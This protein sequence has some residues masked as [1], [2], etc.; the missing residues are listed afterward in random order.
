[1]KEGKRF[2]WYP[3]LCHS[4]FDDLVTILIQDVEAK[5]GYR[6]LISREQSLTVNKTRYFIIIFL[7]LFFPYWF[8]CYVSF[9]LRGVSQKEEHKVNY[10]LEYASALFY[11]VK[12]KSG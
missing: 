5:R 9:P 1:M 4:F 10:N 6:E 11:V 7:F 12:D 2:D 3:V 8:N